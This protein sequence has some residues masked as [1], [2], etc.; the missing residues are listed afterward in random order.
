[1]NSLFVKSPFSLFPMM[2][3]VK[4]KR[5]K[6]VRIL[7]IALIG[8]AIFSLFPE[9]IFAQATAK[10]AFRTLGSFV[11]EK[12]SDIT[13]TTL[14]VFGI[15]LFLQSF[16]SWVL[17][18][19]AIILNQVFFYNTVLNP[20]RMPLIIEM[21]GVMRDLA[22]GFLILI[23]LWVALSIIFSIERYGGKK[24]LVNVILVALLV[25]FSLA[26]VSAVF[27]F[28]N[29]LAKP[30]Q[31][32]IGESIGDVGSVI[33]R[34]ARL[35][36]LFNTLQKINPDELL[37]AEKSEETQTKNAVEGDEQ[38]TSLL[39]PLGATE[40][41][42]S[43]LGLAGCALAGLLLTPVGT[44]ACLGIGLTASVAIALVGAV[45]G[46][47]T[48][49]AET[50]ISFA[51]SLAIVDVILL[52]T[53][54]AFLSAA[55]VLLVRIIAMSFIALFAPL[56]FLA[57]SVPGGYGKKLWDSWIQN[58]FKWAFFAPAFYFLFY[59]SLRVLAA[60]DAGTTA[61]F[62]KS[63]SED[64]G[65]SANP[66]KILNLFI[67]TGFIIASATVSRKIGIGVADG[68]IKWG[69]KWLKAG[70]WA[71]AGA[72]AGAAKAIGRRAAGVAAGKLEGAA[73]TQKPFG[74]ILFPTVMRKGL[75]KTAAAE[76]EAVGEAQKNIQKF[77]SSELQR[78]FNLPFTSATERI[79]IAEELKKRNDIDRQRGVEA[80]Q[81]GDSQLRQS[82][83]LLRRTG[84]SV[85][86][87]LIAR[88]D[89]VS[90]QDVEGAANNEDAFMKF[91]AKI[92]SEEIAKIKWSDIAAGKSD[93]ER[94]KLYD[95]L[96]TQFFNGGPEYIRQM[97]RTTLRQGTAT[98]NEMT[99]SIQRVVNNLSTWSDLE[100]NNAMTYQNNIRYLAGR[101][102][103]ILSAYELPAS[104][105]RDAQAKG[106]ISSG[107]GGGGGGGRRLTINPPRTP[108]INGTS[109]RHFQYD[110][111]ASGGTGTPT[112]TM[113]GN[114]PWL[115]IDANS[116]RISTLSP[117]PA[118]GNYTLTITATDATGTD[119]R[120]I[121]L[122]IG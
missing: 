94:Q 106:I 81:W 49:I 1:M 43:P 2:R 84:I 29:Q 55:L 57:V 11:G 121:N 80:S 37:R 96:T 38:K 14:I 75:Q 102:G 28:T 41:D 19:S 12:L 71:A 15:L 20:A 105:R 58:L 48:G 63:F 3:R 4:I 27:A 59:L 33:M 119:T 26:M 18:F 86:D 92:K 51:L 24:L 54:F 50:G 72:P 122:I 112:W 56:A 101:S 103:K 120:N 6:L 17:N 76:R 113:T 77:T 44:G 107:P 69:D 108:N 111:S 93:A 118:P 16:L 114:P 13:S 109:G 87:L 95:I 70:L 31:N 21:W 88:P 52:I 74:K 35:N 90:T 10:T 66:I 45:T 104:V 100:T 40:T 110:F 42:A 83:G 91:A 34:N 5:E 68:F 23:L 115:T 78:R 89:L 73:W 32:A 9:T 8:I 97:E 36:E 117:P 85:K 98:R 64:L 60:M 25:N 99:Q 7:A 46:A 22:N 53:I 82:L 67:F 39:H 65:I 61:A 116:G 62:G 79:A 30:F 47:A